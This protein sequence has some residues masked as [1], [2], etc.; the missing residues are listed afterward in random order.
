M[1]AIECNKLD[2]LGKRPVD[3]TTR[4][5]WINNYFTSHGYEEVY[6]S[7]VNSVYVKKD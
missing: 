1:V 5:E 2:P 7:D 4:Y 6:E 3:G